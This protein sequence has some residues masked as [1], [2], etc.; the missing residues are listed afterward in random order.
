MLHARVADDE[1]DNLP[2]KRERLL[3]AEIKAS[4]EPEVV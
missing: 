4:N 2:T 1:R 3:H